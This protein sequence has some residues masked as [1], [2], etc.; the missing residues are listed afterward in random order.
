MSKYSLT[1]NGE[2]VTGKNITIRGGSVTVD[3]VTVEGLEL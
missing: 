3:G 2:S 1:I